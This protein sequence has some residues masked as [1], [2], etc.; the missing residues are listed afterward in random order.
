MGF[1]PVSRR[2]CGSRAPSW[3]FARQRPR[4]RDTREG[5]RMVLSRRFFKGSPT[6]H[7]LR[8]LPQL[9]G[10]ESRIVPYATSGNAWPQP[11][12][13]TISFQPD[14]T[15]LGG[16]SS[17]LLASFNG[18]FGSASAWQHAILKAAQTW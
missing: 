6:C 16:I 7:A 9:E 4:W 15:D 10:L 14:G 5:L 11:E 1:A 12:L 13:V 2:C 18:A 8:A 3:A 17:N